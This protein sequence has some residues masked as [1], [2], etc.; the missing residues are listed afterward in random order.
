MRVLAAAGLERAPLRLQGIGRLTSSGLTQ[1][2]PMRGEGEL[3]PQQQQRQQHP[4]FRPSSFTENL[5]PPTACQVFSPRA[6]PLTNTTVSLSGHVTAQTAPKRDAI[7][8]VLP[9]ASH[10]AT[11]ARAVSSVSSRMLINR[12]PG[13]IAWSKRQFAKLP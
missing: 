3:E 12:C 4:S 8:S 9:S 1:R 11:F 6:P 2:R 13:G 5:P 10:R 7:A